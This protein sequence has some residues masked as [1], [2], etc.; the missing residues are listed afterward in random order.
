MTE[1]NETFPSA[2]QAVLLLAAWFAV[3]L[4][5]GAVLGDAQAT[6]GLTPQQGWALTSLIANGCVFA[7]VMQYR[8]LTYRGLF[9]PAGTSMRAT[10]VRLVPWVLLLVP[11]LVLC[12]SML[13][14]VVTRA[15][16]LSDSEQAMFERMTGSDLATVLMACAIAPVVEEM[17]FRGVILRGFLARYGRA[18]AIWGSAALFGLAHLNVYQ[19][20]AAL[21]LGAVCGW[22]YERSRSLVPSIA[23]HAAYN[24]TLNVLANL[25]PNDADSTQLTLTAGV[26]IASMLLAG[27]GVEFLRRAFDR[28]DE[29]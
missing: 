21:L 14:D 8:G 18:Q 5:V 17:L 27:V 1:R 11:A 24:T 10:A 2:L 3:E 25:G 9:H 23:L 22:L 7:T 28:P 6:L 15:F 29:H 19:F 12:V 26:W 16:P 20:V 13:V 4:A